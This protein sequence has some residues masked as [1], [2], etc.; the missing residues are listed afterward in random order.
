MTLRLQIIIGI[1]LAA[2]LFTIISAV[3]ARRLEF[4]LSLPWLL[5]LLVLLIMDIFPGI[6][7]WLTHLLG[8]ELPINMLTFCGL[9]FSLVLIFILTTSLSRLNERQKK[10]VQEVALLKKRL[11]G[12]EREAAESGAGR[13][14]S[15]GA[16]NCA[17]HGASAGA[18][19]C[20]GRGASAGTEDE[21]K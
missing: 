12:L 2:S 10:L 18:E 9:G 16:E 7:D 17:G 13:G 3:R 6:V 20:A 11:E 5:L 15:A 1:V 4:R 14:A 8:I 19:N 21:M